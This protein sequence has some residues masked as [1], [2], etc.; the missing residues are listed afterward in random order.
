M[1]GAFCR[2]D[3][4]KLKELMKDEAY[5]HLSE[6]TWQAVAIMTDSARMVAKMKNYKRNE[7]Q[8]GY[9]MCQAM[10]ELMQDYWNDGKAEGTRTVVL[11]ML[12]R[13]F[14]TEEIC[15]LVECDAS[16]VE[17]LRKSIKNI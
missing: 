10:E 6:D 17:E 16:F 3:K 14:R 12:K 7:E 11:N 8:G 1:E 9:D 5:A 2:K 4:L 15:S 13:G